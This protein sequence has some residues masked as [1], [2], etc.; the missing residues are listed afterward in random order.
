MRPASD[1]ITSPCS[2]KGEV[3]TTRRAIGV[4]VG[5]WLARWLLR[6][7]RAGLRRPM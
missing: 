2:R 5:I 7:Q 3:D 4:I 6:W 1:G